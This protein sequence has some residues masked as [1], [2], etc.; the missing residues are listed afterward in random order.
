[1]GARPRRARLFNRCQGSSG[2][3]GEGVLGRVKWLIW[4]EKKVFGILHALPLL[5]VTKQTGDA[6]GDIGAGWKEDH[7]RK[8]L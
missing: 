2:V 7:H 1:M 4:W 6:L 3:F 5:L 8:V